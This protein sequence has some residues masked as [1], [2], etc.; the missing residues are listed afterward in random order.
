[1]NEQLT[2]PSGHLALC[3]AMPSRVAELRWQPSVD[4][5]ADERTPN[6]GSRAEV[7][8]KQMWVDLTARRRGRVTV[9][10]PPGTAVAVLAINEK[11]HPDHLNLGHDASKDLRRRYLQP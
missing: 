10:R 5:Y 8:S 2:Q 1:M 11:S 9:V 4:V 7:M 3:S 6:I